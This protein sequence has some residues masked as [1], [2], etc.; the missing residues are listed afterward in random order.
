MC[1]DKLI[2]QDLTFV[3]WCAIYNMT[4]KPKNENKRWELNEI[5]WRNTKDWN[6]EFWGGEK[7]I[8]FIHFF[9]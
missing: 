3:E 9:H 7:T 5:W 2:R 4:L 6:I 8:N 1:L